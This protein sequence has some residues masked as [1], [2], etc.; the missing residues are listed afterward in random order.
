M[1]TAYDGGTEPVWKIG[2]DQ[3]LVAAFYR[4]TAIHVL[5][6]RAIGELALLTVSE[7]EPD[8]ELP[9]RRRAEVA[10]GGRAVRDLLK[11]EFFFPGRRRVRRRTCDRARAAGR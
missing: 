2:D 10:G 4:N 5:V 3:H 6:D 11:F 1:L 7:L 8:A 9:A